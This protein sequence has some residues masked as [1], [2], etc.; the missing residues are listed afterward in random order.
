MQKD[1]SG[2]GKD[3]GRRDTKPTS[4]SPPLHRPRH[5][6]VTLP[7]PQK[8]VRVLSSASVPVPQHSQHASSSAVAQPASPR[9]VLLVHRQQRFGSSPP[10]SPSPWSS[11]P[12]SLGVEDGRKLPARLILIQ[13]RRKVR[14]AL[15]LAAFFSYT[16]SPAPRCPRA[17]IILE[18]GRGGHRG[19]RRTHLSLS[20]KRMH[21]YIR[22]YMRTRSPLRLRHLRGIFTSISE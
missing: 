20:P 4:D 11:A 9:R 13:R 15:A 7:H 10:A 18:S 1:S 21:V 12:L 22:A 3:R 16:S 14:L 5:C 19:S 17:F 2:E 6:L 8:Y